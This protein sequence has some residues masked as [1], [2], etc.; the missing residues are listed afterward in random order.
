MLLQVAKLYRSTAGARFASA[1]ERSHPRGHPGGPG[2]HRLA[3]EGRPHASRSTPSWRPSSASS[4]SAAPRARATAPWPTAW[5]GHRPPTGRQAWPP[6]SAI[7]CTS[8]A[9]SSTGA[10]CPSRGRGH[11]GR[12]PLARRPGATPGPRA[13]RSGARGSSRAS[14]G[15][16]GAASPWR[17]VKGSGRRRRDPRRGKMDWVTTKVTRSYRCPD[18]SCTSRAHVQAERIERWAVAQSP[19][20]RARARAR[21]QRARP[22]RPRGRAGQGRAAPRAGVAPEAQDALGDAW[23]STVKARRTER[24]TAARELGEARRDAGVQ[25]RTFDLE[26]LVGAGDTQGLRAALAFLWKAIRVGRKGPGGTPLTFVSRGSGTAELQ[27][28]LGDEELAA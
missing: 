3:P 24:D 8:P 15:A 25:A 22:R 20:R 4:T 18:R 12:A 13:A 5:A 19:A 14:Y 21:R 28:E 26:E 6:S 16:P 9:A 2:G 17:P 7:A 1:K 10:S 11:R 27:L 23:A